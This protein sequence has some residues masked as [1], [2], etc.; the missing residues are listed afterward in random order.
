[1]SFGEMAHG[2]FSNGFWKNFNVGH[3][4]LI[5]LA[6]IGWGRFEEQFS[7]IA[8]AQTSQQ[9]QIN[10]TIKNG[11]EHS[12]RTEISQQAQIDDLNRR[13][14]NDEQVLQQLVPKV[15]RIDTNVLVL[16]NKR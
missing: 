4:I 1:M 11:T 14:N 2:V 3:V 10:D 8:K 13:I 5:A 12:N 15:E 9:T 7:E 6:L 16:M